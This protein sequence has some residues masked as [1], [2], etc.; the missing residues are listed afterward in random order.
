MAVEVAPLAPGIVR[1]RRAKTARKTGS[2]SFFILTI[3]PP[4]ITL[5]RCRLE[6]YMRDWRDVAVVWSRSGLFSASGGSEQND[7]SQDLCDVY[8][9]QVGE[10]RFFDEWCHCGERIDGQSIL[11][12]KH[13]CEDHEAEAELRVGIA[14]DSCVC[15]N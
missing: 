13:Y 4:A 7:H 14:V 15:K 5:R 6:F 11:G 10:E 12:R 2:C 8:S 9:K 1:T 3:S